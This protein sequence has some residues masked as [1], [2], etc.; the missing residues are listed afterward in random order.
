MIGA[1]EIEAGLRELGVQPGDL[2]LVHCSLSRFGLVAGGEQTV[3]ES[4]RRAVGRFGTVAM[5]AQSWHLCDP[6]FLNDPELDAPARDAMR[7]SLPAYDLRL[8]PTR[9]MGRVA[10]LFRTLPGAVRSPHPHRSFAAEG[11]A[12]ESITGRH[13]LA[14]PFGEDSPLTRLCAENATVLLLGV[15]YDSCTALHLAETRA[16]RGAPRAL[17]RNGAPMTVDGERR[18]V[19]WSEPVVD[20]ARFIEIGEAFEALGS[21]RTARIGDAVCR[22]VPMSSLV[23]FAE[24]TLATMVA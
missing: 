19:S 7:R 11:P 23:D 18:W 4:L 5:P 3:V 17:V 20:D 21:V 8:T 9:T 24:A 6:D 2:L 15:G 1:N 10:E 14:D 13:E 22:S 16:Y 12:A